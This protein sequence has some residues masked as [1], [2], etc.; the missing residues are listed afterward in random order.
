[1]RPGLAVVHV[2]SSSFL[3]FEVVSSCFALRVAAVL[4]H[5]IWILGRADRTRARA[6]MHLARH[7]ESPTYRVPMC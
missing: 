7:A 5:V 3:S 2:R 1:M 4:H 6:A